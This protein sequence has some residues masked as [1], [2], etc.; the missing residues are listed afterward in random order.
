M[1]RKKSGMFIGWSG[2]VED[3]LI[4][5]LDG[6]DTDPFRTELVEATDQNYCGLMAKQGTGHSEAWVR[7]A[8][9]VTQNP[10]DRQLLL[11][12]MKCSIWLNVAFLFLNK[13][14]KQNQSNKQNQTEI[15][16]KDPT[17]NHLK[18]QTWRT[19][20]GTDQVWICDL[21][22]PHAVVLSQ[23]RYLCWILTILLKTTL[24]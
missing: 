10:E 7:T 11:M 16:K 1:R 20:A 24:P 14:N 9:V 8:R 15:S 21:L 6:P 5:A 23:C 17:Q 3:L 22:C 13:T 18:G 4:L 19:E 2:Q 12:T